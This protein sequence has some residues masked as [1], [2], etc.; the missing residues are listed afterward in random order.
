MRTEEGRKIRK[1]FIAPEGCQLMAA[2]YSQVE[3]RIMAH[4]SND[5]GLVSAFEQGLDVHASTAAEVFGIDLKDVTSDQRRSAKA[6]NFG[7]MYGM[8]SFGLGQQ[9]GMSRDEAQQHIDVY[10]SRYPKVKDYVEQSRKTASEKGYVETLFGRRIV[11][12]EINAK[13]GLRRKAAERAAINAPLQGTAADIIKVAMISVQQWLD[14]TKSQ[15]KM[16]MQ[17]HDELVFEV[18]ND[19]IDDAKQH[20]VHCMQGAATL[21]V[22]LIVDVGI[23]NNWDEA[24]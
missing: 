3:L 15:V 5:P 21:S 11:V 9:L 6:I 18:P 14:A 23:G 12:P 19:Q 24:H 8:S 1:A 10:F 17:V 22:P 16:V 7:L 4:L 2:D 13:N 20:I